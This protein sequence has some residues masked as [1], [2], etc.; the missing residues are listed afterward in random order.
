M[1]RQS[2]EC[3]RGLRPK[4]RGAPRHWDLDLSDRDLRKLQKPAVRQGNIDVICHL[5]LV[6]ELSAT[7]DGPRPGA[8]I[9]STKAQNQLQSF[10]LA[11]L[12]R[13]SRPVFMQLPGWLIPATHFV[14]V[15]RG[16]VLHGAIINDLIR[17]I[18]TLAGMGFVLVGVEHIWVSKKVAQGSIT[19]GK[20]IAR[21]TFVREESL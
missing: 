18:V 4:K 8:T 15:I 1:S 10:Q 13:S 2:T 5:S 6:G 14:E 7:Y 16:I 12:I 11:W 21:K 17:E 9:I 3:I 20:L 19:S